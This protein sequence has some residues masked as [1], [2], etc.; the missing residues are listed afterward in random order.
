MA[1]QISCLVAAALAVLQTVTATA[2]Q[3]PEPARQ[4]DERIRS[5]N[6]RLEQSRQGQRDRDRGQGS[7]LA[8]AEKS[9]VAP[10]G[11]V[12]FPKDWRNKIRKRA[13]LGGANLTTQEKAVRRAL[14]SPV[15]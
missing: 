4:A 2:A 15:N 9:A 13:D 7:S 10:A 6:E 11:D 5:A 3:P 1:R 12:Q 8:E 14:D